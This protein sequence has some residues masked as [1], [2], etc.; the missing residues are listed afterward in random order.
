[1]GVPMMLRVCRRCGDVVPRHYMV[2]MLC[3][4]CHLDGYIPR[5]YERREEYRR[6]SAFGHANATRRPRLG[7]PFMDMSTCRVRQIQLLPPMWTKPKPLWLQLHARRVACGASGP[8][9]AS[10]RPG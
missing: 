10:A 6:D 1:M 5:G 3:Y 7:V 4:S 2:A 9:T 8:R